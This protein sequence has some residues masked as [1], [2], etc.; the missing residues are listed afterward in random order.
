MIGENGGVANGALDQL[1]RARLLQL[2]S[3]FDA[4]RRLAGEPL[5]PMP[6]RWPRAGATDARHPGR[7][8]AALEATS[9]RDPA[10]GSVRKVDAGAALI[11]AGRYA[12]AIHVFTLAQMEIRARRGADRTT[13]AWI[14]TA[15]RTFMHAI[16]I[17][18]PTD[19]DPASVRV[20]IDRAEWTSRRRWTTAA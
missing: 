18:T 17:A 5:A 14:A 6:S 19:V 11:T 1:A 16:A 8:P 20:W 13:V 7:A 4:L 12:D 3:L 10:V 9:T 2:Q 15:T